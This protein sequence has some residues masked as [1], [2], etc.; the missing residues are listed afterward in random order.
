MDFGKEVVNWYLE[1]KRDLPWRNTRD[2]FKIWLSEVLLQQTKVEQGT[3]YYL[4]FIARF[5]NV[6]ELAQ[7]S[8]Q[9]I[10][11]LW[12]G[13][14]YY[15]RARNLHY[16]SQQI[17]TQYSGSF[18]TN[19]KELLK[20][21]GVGE[22]TAG[23]IASICYNEKVAIV[24]G[25]VYRVL[26]R[27]LSIDTPI[28]TTTGKREFKAIAQLL[29]ENNNPS[30]FNQGIME[31]GATICTPKQPN[32]ATCPLQKACS[33]FAKNNILEYPVKAK[34]TKQKKRF[35]NYL[36]LRTPNDSF[37]IEKRKDKDIWQNMYQF[38]LIETNSETNSLHLEDTIISTKSAVIY[39]APKH[40]L[41]HQIIYTK[42]WEFRINET[43][44]KNN[45]QWILINKNDISQYPFPKLIDNYIQERI[46]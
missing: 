42:F 35:F 34:K 30:H 9:E 17:V 7:A 27:F 31:L 25:N 41:S 10:L 1:N 19:Y 3:S 5:A 21:K 32:C 11:K 12:Q 28:D 8:E 44:L 18:P 16:A 14:G 33:S 26:S 22:Y 46:L 24:D 2:P 39:N 40:I 29:L 13:L 38:P 15:S 23:A 36:V 6:Q 37:Y 4:K 45:K 20:L 43:F